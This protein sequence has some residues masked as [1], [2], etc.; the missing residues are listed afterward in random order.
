MRYSSSIWSSCS[1]SA[2][3]AIRRGVC[4]SSGSQAYGTHPHKLGKASASVQ[5]LYQAAACLAACANMAQPATT[6]RKAI[7]KGRGAGRLRTRQDR[8][9]SPLQVCLYPVL[10]IVCR[11]RAS[12]QPSGQ[13]E[14]SQVGRRD[15]CSWHI[16]QASGDWPVDHLTSWADIPNAKSDRPYKGSVA[17]RLSMLARNLSIARF[18]S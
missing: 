3:S 13:R 2:H 1:R 17:A 4:S 7:P 10:G 12:G 6:L 9:P 5:R 8:V 18:T 16:K 15:G 11:F 14:Q